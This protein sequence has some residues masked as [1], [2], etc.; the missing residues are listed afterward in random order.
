[1]ESI[2]VFKV[3]IVGSAY[4]LKKNGTTAWCLKTPW[5]NTQSPKQIMFPIDLK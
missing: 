3:T 2:E 1:M 5:I 4:A